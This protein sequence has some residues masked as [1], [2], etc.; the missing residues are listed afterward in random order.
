VAKRLKPWRDLSPSYRRRLE[1]AGVTAQSR[2]RGTD[3]RIARGHRPP[4]RPG[5]APADLIVSEP[6]DA[7]RAR[8]R[9][10][11]ETLAPDWLPNREN[12]GDAVAAS[13]SQLRHPR[14]WRRV[15]FYPAPAGQSW[16]MKVTYTRG[17]PQEIEIPPDL[18]NEVLDL[19]ALVQRAT[20]Y[21]ADEAAW[22]AYIDRG[23]DYDVH[24]TP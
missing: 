8:R 10:W 12:M 18:Y 23:R 5:Q 3:L 1:R 7:Q 16:Q 20:G 14:Y 9:I 4:P 6:T 21:V 17:H 24:G 13:L 2:R 15:D 11:R 19:L 22:Q